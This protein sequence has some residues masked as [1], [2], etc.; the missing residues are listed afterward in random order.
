MSGSKPQG[1]LTP[2]DR[3]EIHAQ[4]F[5][6]IWEQAE[7]DPATSTCMNYIHFRLEDANNTT[8]ERAFTYDHRLWSPAECIDLLEE[9]GFQ[10]IKTLEPET[11]L[12]HADFPTDSSLTLIILAFA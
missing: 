3:D 4:G 6:A 1:R 12:N 2:E 11:R 9:V 7:F 10:D 8:I 5:T